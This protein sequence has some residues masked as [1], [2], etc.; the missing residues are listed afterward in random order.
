MSSAGFKITIPGIVSISPISSQHW[1]LAPS[2]PTEI[3]ACVAP[4]LTLTPLGADGNFS[5][6]LI[7]QIVNSEQ[8][9]RRLIS[10]LIGTIQSKNFQGVDIDFEYILLEDRLAF[11]QF[12]VDVRNAFFNLL[13]G[14]EILELARTGITGLTRGCSDVKF[15]D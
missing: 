12:V 2:S 4:I 8:K 3:P 9:K 11:V 14:Y 5:N 1:W 6:Y 15:L 13:E 7:S 10:D